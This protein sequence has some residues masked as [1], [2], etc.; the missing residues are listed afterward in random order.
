[1]CGVDWGDG[2]EA[3]PLR[4]LTA[5]GQGQLRAALHR[6]KPRAHHSLDAG[7]VQQTGVAHEV[8][9]LR[10]LC[11]GRHG[12]NPEAG[13]AV[14]EGEIAEDASRLRERGSQG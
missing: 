8:E 6:R 1:M 2:E 9:H 12:V 4:R 14:L 10:G 13:R 3:A 7:R 5:H 11:D